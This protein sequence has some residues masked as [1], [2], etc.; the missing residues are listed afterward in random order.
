MIPMKIH[1]DGDNCW[2]DLR[3]KADKIVHVIGLEA[4][5]LLGGTTSG[6]T[7]VAF[8]FDLEDGRIVIAETSLALLDTAVQGMRAKERTVK[9]RQ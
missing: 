8:R 4:A 2:P 9:E 5:M 1:L 7:S 3:D 6:A